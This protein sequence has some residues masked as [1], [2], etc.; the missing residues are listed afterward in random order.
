MSR[1]QSK[2]VQETLETSRTPVA[3]RV[4]CSG[5]WKT[6]HMAQPTTQKSLVEF[7]IFFFFFLSIFIRRSQ[8]FYG[9]LCVTISLS[10]AAWICK[11]CG[12][13]IVYSNR[14]LYLI[15]NFSISPFTTIHDA[16]SKLFISPEESH[17]F[18]RRRH[19]NSFV[20][21]KAYVT[22]CAYKTKSERI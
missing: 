6:L 10:Y 14:C 4:N 12:Y 16:S 1:L 21:A 11:N 5:S 17:K 15:Y 19:F 20:F 9:F 2:Q 18:N 3:V 22:L 7:F 13:A 8:H